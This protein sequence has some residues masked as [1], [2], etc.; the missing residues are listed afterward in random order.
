MKA[1]R[2]GQSTSISS[3]AWNGLDRS[4]IEQ[5]RVRA[6]RPI[7]GKRERSSTPAIYPRRSRAARRRKRGDHRTVDEGA[8]SP[9]P[10]SGCHKARFRL[11]FAGADSAPGDRTRVREEPPPSANGP[12]GSYYAHRADPDTPAE[13]TMEAFDR[14]V[15]ARSAP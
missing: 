11:S 10:D 1:I 8:R 12:A 15:P 6:A 9:Q 5:G 7:Q 2:L 3:V 14:L 13:E 4:K